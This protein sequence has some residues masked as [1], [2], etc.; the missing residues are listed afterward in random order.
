MLSNTC[1]YA[2]RAIIYL[3]LYDGENR[4]IGI[5][6]ISKE[7]NIPTPF[8]GKILQLLAKNKLLTSTKGP[9]G[10]FGLAKPPKEITLLSIIQII[11]GLDL[12]TECLI[13]LSSC[14]PTEHNDVQCPI[15]K[16]YE[17][18]S[19]QIYEM[20][21]TENIENLKNEILASEGK[22]GL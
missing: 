8:L 14:K 6:E 18:I 12:F 10:G 20:F 22:I 17:P 16:R 2:I 19:K 11:D 21:D 13:G 4:K 1:K 15:H 9:N 5:K 7:L 3:A